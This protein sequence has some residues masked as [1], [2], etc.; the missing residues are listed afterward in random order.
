MIESELKKT[1]GKDHVILAV[2]PISNGVQ[3]HL[4]VEQGLLR[5]FGRLAVMGMEH[6]SAASASGRNGSTY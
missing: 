2:R 4:E 6:G 1:P 3:V 5:L